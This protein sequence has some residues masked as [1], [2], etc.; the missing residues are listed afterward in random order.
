MQISTE[1]DNTY[2]EKL[3]QLQKMMGKN[4]RTF[5]EFAIDDL[6]TRHKVAVC[7]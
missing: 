1:L 7:P 6:Y 3:Q 2:Y 4:L 5:L